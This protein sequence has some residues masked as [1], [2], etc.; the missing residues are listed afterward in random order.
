MIDRD[1]R[2]EN[3]EKKDMGMEESHRY[4]ELVKTPSRHIA[5]GMVLQE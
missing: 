3:S 2:S 1:S 5:G 4:W